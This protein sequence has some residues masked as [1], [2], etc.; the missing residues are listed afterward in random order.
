MWHDPVANQSLHLVIA[1]V[2]ELTINDAQ[3]DMRRAY[4]LGAP[5]V[6]VSGLLW[7]SA[8]LVSVLHSERMAVVVLLLGGAAIHPLAVALTRLL[9]GSGRHA[10][11]NALGSLAAEGTFW[12]IATCALAYGIQALRI[13][14]FF[15]AM[16][17]AIGGR[18]FSFQTLYGLRVYWLCAAALCAAGLVLALARAP[19]AVGAFAGAGIELVVAAVLFVRVSRNI[20][21]SP[22]A[23]NDA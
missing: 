11:G 1:P 3:A 23:A 13:E 20:A 4:L 2:P 8:G 16:L 9:G 18:Y 22:F 19:V 6:L 14:W 15:P 7:L 12:L 21:D 5:G 17:L 10:A